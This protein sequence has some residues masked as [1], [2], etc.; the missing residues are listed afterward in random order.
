MAFDPEVV[1]SPPSHSRA[2]D[3][4][5]SHAF[6]LSW[7]ND[8]SFHVAK[9]ALMLR[10]LR[11]KAQADIA[12]DMGTSQSA[13]ARIEGGDENIT[14]RT[15]RRLA[16]A[17][18]GRIRFAIEPAEA[19][20][21]QWPAWWTVVGQG[22]MVGAPWTFRG[23]V[24]KLHGS[25]GGVLAAWS[26]QDMPPSQDTLPD[27]TMVSEVTSNTATGSQILTPV[28]GALSLTGAEPAPKTR[29][30]RRIDV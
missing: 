7:D 14:L 17:L 1:P 18:A 10:R 30:R 11:G 20:S 5:K 6:L 28:T 22:V 9:H 26:A 8:I 25:Q 23:A 3:L 29:A 15:L 4:Y 16:E 19:A 27:A 12:K 2:T 24:M 21:P 13:V